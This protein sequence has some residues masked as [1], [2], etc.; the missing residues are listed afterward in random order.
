ML[1]SVIL[2]RKIEMRD[3]SDMKR[4]ENKFVWNF[5]GEN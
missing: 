4:R 1:I 3:T 5:G 2:K